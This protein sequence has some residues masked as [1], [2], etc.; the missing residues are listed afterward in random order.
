MEKVTLYLEGWQK[1]MLKDFARI[2]GVGRITTMM[3]KPGKGACPASYKI[4]VSGMKKDDWLIYL[5][6]AQMLEVKAQLGLRTPISS[7]NINKEAIE[8]GSIAFR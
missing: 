8:A 2:K 6:D 7:I 3:I 5:T 1:R 4:P